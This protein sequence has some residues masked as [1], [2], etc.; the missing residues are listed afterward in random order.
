MKELLKK[1]LLASCVLFI[2][3]CIIAQN[4]IIHG[5]NVN[6]GLGSIRGIELLPEGR[7]H[8]V[9]EL[10][11]KGYI[12]YK[13]NL[14]L[15]YKIRLD[16]IEKPFFYDLDISIGM[17]KYKYDYT[18]L[19]EEDGIAGFFG[20]SGDVSLIYLS[21]SP[22]LNYNIFKGLY[23]GVGVEPTILR[24]SSS[25]MFSTMFDIPVTAR[26]GYDFKFFDVSFGYKHGLFSTVKNNKAGFSKGKIN[27]WSIQFFI[28]L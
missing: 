26:I 19:V 2:T 11:G 9:L 16:N 22:T 1:L 20:I 23:S 15:G 4:K 3:Q 7:I 25:T 12:D 17:K 13:Y 27:E 28:P 6:G 10:N 8:D 24:H 14:A 18:V 21:L 5:F